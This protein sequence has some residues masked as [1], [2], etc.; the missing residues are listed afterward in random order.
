MS[1]GATSAWACACGSL[2]YSAGTSWRPL[3][4][5]ASVCVALGLLL[6][7]L[8]ARFG[9]ALGDLAICDLLGHHTVAAAEER[10]ARVCPLLVD[11]IGFDKVL[12]IAV[13]PGET[14]RVDDLQ[15]HHAAKRVVGDLQPHVAHHD[16]LARPD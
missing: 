2:A 14:R 1:S 4:F 12:R 8:R 7:P 13:D 9:V 15:P 6:V 16:A 5:S 10:G 3:A 11:D